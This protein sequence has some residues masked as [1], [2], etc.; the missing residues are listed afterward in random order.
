[1]VQ[2]YKVLSTS[3]FRS[4]HSCPSPGHMNML[5]Q[6][7]P[8]FIDP[9]AIRGRYYWVY[10]MNL[11]SVV[12]FI[13]GIHF[14]SAWHCEG[15]LWAVCNLLR[16]LSWSRHVDIKTEFTCGTF[17][18]L[19]SAHSS[20]P[21]ITS[22]RRMSM[23]TAAD[24]KRAGGISTTYAGRFHSQRLVCFLSPSVIAETG[25]K[26]A[27]ILCLIKSEIQY[28]DLICDLMPSWDYSINRTDVFF[29][30]FKLF[31]AQL[32]VLSHLLVWIWFHLLFS[33]VAHTQKRKKLGWGM[34]RAENVLILFFYSWVR[35]T[36]TWNASKP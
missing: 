29:G 4:H 12:M 32:R 27:T 14:C 24:E 33:L 7:F 31:K 25:N 5:E 22:N 17:S 23:C 6:W 16:C 9:P 21:G 35:N 18:T 15:R 28:Y 3:R 10:S 8:T 34:C 11:L 26:H 1:M 36:L 2:A 19:L 20:T 30:V 13:N